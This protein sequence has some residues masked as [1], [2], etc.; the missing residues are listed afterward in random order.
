MGRKHQRKFL[1]KKWLGTLLKGLQVALWLVADPAS[2]LTPPLR[3][4][5]RF[6]VWNGNFLGGLVRWMASGSFLWLHDT[7]GNPRCVS[8][9]QAIVV[10]GSL[11]SKLEQVK[12][13][14]E[15]SEVVASF[16]SVGP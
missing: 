6:S 7:F 16:D 2:E 13:A 10:S 12:V 3:P 11:V 15:R 5:C 1:R 14:V 8:G 9:F 4:E